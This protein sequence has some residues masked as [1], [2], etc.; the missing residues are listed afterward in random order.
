[1][2][3]DYIYKTNRYSLPL[4]N[5]ISFVAIKSTF[6]L[7]FA[8]IKDK[9]DNTYKVILNYLTYE[10]LNLELPQTILTNKE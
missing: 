4:L 9:K 6:Y 8:F 2:L 3:I 10:S 5:I 1:M 7:V